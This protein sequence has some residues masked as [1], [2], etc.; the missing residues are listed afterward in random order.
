M[1]PFSELK[2]DKSQIQSLASNLKH[3]MTQRGMTET[4]L[5]KIL[6]L[7]LMTIRRIASGE[8][9]D[10]RIST[11]KLIS[12]Y[13]NVPVDMLLSEEKMSSEIKSKVAASPQFVPILNW[14]MVCDRN[15]LNVRM[16]T[17][18]NWQPIAN[19][20]GQSLSPRSFAL[21]SKPSLQ[22]R[23]PLGSL[24]IIDPDEEPDDGDLLLVRIGSNSELSFREL[25]IDPPNW[26]L[27]PVVLGSDL[28]KFNKNA[29][30]IVGVVML[31][32]LYTKK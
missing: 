5:A 27:Q 18:D 7:P 22:P 9:V 20:E 8:T 4:E 17:W 12:D 6:N 11:L 19:S 32:L 31:T 30:S 16:E 3:L 24:I 10:P 14:E 21:P 15:F 26:L 23:F 13:F 29:D 1:K 2:I 28:L 25:M